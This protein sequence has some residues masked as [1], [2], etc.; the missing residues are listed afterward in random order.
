MGVN[1][2]NPSNVASR[3]VLKAGAQTTPL[4][5]VRRACL[6]RVDS[7][8]LRKCPQSTETLGREALPSYVASGNPG[9]CT[10]SAIHATFNAMPTARGWVSRAP[11][12]RQPGGDP[13]THQRRPTGNA[14]HGNVWPRSQRLAQPACAPVWGFRPSPRSRASRRPPA[15]RCPRRYRCRKAGSTPPTRTAPTSCTPT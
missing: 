7:S 5:K 4:N 13:Y 11:D 8:I 10:Q 9:A 15:A 14:F 3:Q 1:S 2:V 12:T 6:R